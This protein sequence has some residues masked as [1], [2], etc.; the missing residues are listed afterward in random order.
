MLPNSSPAVSSWA[1]TSRVIASTHCVIV[2]L[3]SLLG[4]L[5]LG[6]TYIETALYRQVPKE[7]FERDLGEGRKLQVDPS[8]MKDNSNRVSAG[9]G[10]SP[11]DSADAR[12]EPDVKRSGGGLPGI[13]Q[14]LPK[15]STSAPISNGPGR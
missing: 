15:S 2:N 10:G 6:R 8:T 3:A 13:S 5:L 4:G 1:V 14:A 9:K 12:A 11:S 7:K